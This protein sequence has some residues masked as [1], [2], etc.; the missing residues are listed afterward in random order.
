VGIEKGELG[1]LSQKKEGEYMQRSK[2]VPETNSFRIEFCQEQARSGHLKEGLRGGLP[3]ISG[4]LGKV[5]GGTTCGAAHDLP[6]KVA[7]SWGGKKA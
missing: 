7:K 4:R 5:K 2:T 1:L 3:S 6:K